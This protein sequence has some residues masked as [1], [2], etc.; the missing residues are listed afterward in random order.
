[1]S[2]DVSQ[3]LAFC[4]LHDG[5]LLGLLFSLEMEATNS[6]GTSVDFQRTARRYFPEDNPHNCRYENLKS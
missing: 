1:M 6:S 3:C 2:T 5:F 4:L